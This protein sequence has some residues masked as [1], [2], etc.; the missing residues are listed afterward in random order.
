MKDTSEEA[1]NDGNNDEDNEIVVYADDDT[2]I[3]ADKDPI[4]LQD[5][6]QNEADIVTNWFSRNDMV[7][8]S[9]KTKLLIVGTN[10]NRISKL[11]NQDLTLKVNVCGEVKEETTSEKLLGIIVNNSATFKNHFYGD[12]ENTG[13]FKQLSTRVTMLKRLKKFMSPAR[14]KLIM[15]GLFSSKM[16]YGMTVWGRVWNIPGDLDEGTRTSPTMT[17]E[18][19]RKVQVLQNKCLRLVTNCDYKTPT[20]TLIKKTNSLS[21]HQ[22]IAHLSLCQVY[23]IFQ[24]RNPVYHYSR[25]FG[26]DSTDTHPNT[27][28]TNDCSTKRIEFKLSM[29]RS[30]LF[31]QSSRLWAALPNQVKSYR[32]KSVF[33]KQAL[34]GTREAAMDRYLIGMHTLHPPLSP[35]STPAEI[36]WRTCLGGGVGRPN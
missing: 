1:G 7:C 30:S 5:K 6:I 10:A 21:V 20:S 18:D 33:K 23:T 26:K 12:E 16:I 9:E 3:T 32:S 19:L 27:R 17:K 13:L 15:E 4:M 24:T 29:A 36:V 31:Y 8:S 2:P 25:L 11:I 14:L 28:T 22:R 35:P 34:C